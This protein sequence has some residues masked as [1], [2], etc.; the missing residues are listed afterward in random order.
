MEACRAIVGTDSPGGIPELVRD[1][2]NGLLVQPDDVAGLAA[3]IHRLSTDEALRAR[4]GAAGRTR[5][6]EEFAAERMT[7]R[8][9]RTYTA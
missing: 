4:L 1:G 5:Y 9:L 8:T 6:D 3:A 2:H 7:E